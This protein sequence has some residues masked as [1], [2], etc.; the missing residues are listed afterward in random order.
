[1][2]EKVLLLLTLLGGTLGALVAMRYF[3]HKT[4]KVEFQRKFW[5]VLALQIVVLIIWFMWLRPMLHQP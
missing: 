2:P 5:L 4:A 3:G 1:V